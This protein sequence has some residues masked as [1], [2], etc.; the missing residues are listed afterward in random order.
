MPNRPTDDLLSICDCIDARRVKATQG[1]W[2][3]GPYLDH[4]SYVTAAD[5]DVAEVPLAA[6]ADYIAAVN[7]VAMA[8]VTAAARASVV[9]E[10]ERDAARAQL[11]SLEEVLRGTGAHQGDDAGPRWLPV[12]VFPED[13]EYW[14]Y[15]P[16]YRTTTKQSV[17][18]SFGERFREY[19]RENGFRFWSEPIT[20]PKAPSPPDES[21]PPAPAEVGRG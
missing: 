9:L 16:R 7:P 18:Q 12:G 21:A 20:E 4:G 14:R 11:A 13:G 3:S 2:T 15:D 10:A 8:I 17:R 1:A 6:D 5:R 19:A